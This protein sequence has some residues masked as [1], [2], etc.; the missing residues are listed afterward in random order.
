M[1]LLGNSREVDNPEAIQHTPLFTRGT[2]PPLQNPR[3]R[4]LC[5]AFAQ[6]LSLAHLNSSNRFSHVPDP[7]LAQC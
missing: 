1:H 4:L 2:Q 3:E 6:P 5:S 7:E